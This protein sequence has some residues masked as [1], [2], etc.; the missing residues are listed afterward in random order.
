MRNFLTAMAAIISL[1]PRL[2]RVPPPNAGAFEAAE[3]VSGTDIAYSA[4]SIAMGTVV[5]EVTVDE[6][7]MVEGVC[8]IREIQSLTETAVELVKNCRFKPAVLNGQPMRSRTVVAVTFNPALR[9][10]RA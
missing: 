7:G 5:L 8:P 6:K 4:K 10:I 9:W 3:I 1:V 2:V